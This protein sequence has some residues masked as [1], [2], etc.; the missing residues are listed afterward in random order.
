VAAIDNFFS[1]KKKNE[2]VDEGDFAS[3]RQP[4]QEAHPS[5]D[6]LQER[7]QRKRKAA[8]IGTFFPQSEETEIVEIANLSIPAAESRNLNCT[9]EETD[10]PTLSSATKE[11]SYSLEQPL[12]NVSIHENKMPP[13]SSSSSS[14]ITDK[15]LELAKKLQASFDREN[16]IFSTVNRLKD[17]HKKK[18]RRI[19]TF[20][21]KR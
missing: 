2:S 17:P 20:F 5:K 19:D 18:V 8:D 12:T 21:G 1:K 13:T 4:Q 14:V 9:E 15:D 6:S 10:V 7:Q 11:T 3:S 16:Y